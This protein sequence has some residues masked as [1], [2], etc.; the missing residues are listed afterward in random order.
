M[1]IRMKNR[2]I[3]SVLAIIIFSSCGDGLGNSYKDLFN[4]IEH[5]YVSGITLDSGVFESVYFGKSVNLHATL[6]PPDATDQKVTWSIVSGSSLASVNSEKGILRA[7]NTAGDIRVRAV[8]RDGGFSAE[9]VITI[10]GVILPG[11]STIAV[12]HGKMQ[13]SFSKSIYNYLDAPIPWSVSSVSIIP[14]AVQGGS[15]IM[16]NGVPAESGMPYNL[17]VNTGSNPVSVV[18]TAADGLSYLTYDVDIYRAVPVYKTGAGSINGYILDPREDGSIRRG[19]AWPNPR[20]S[21]NGNGTITDKM[22]GLVWIKNLVPHGA[23]NDWNNSLSSSEN[24]I[25][26]GKTDWRLPNVR[27]LLSMH[28]WGEPAQNWLLKSGFTG[29]PSELKCW[30]SSIDPATSS[31]VWGVY[32]NYAISIIEKNSNQYT[33]D[34]YWWAVRSGS[35]LQSTGQTN[36]TTSGEDGFYQKGV[37][38]PIKHFCI[39]SNGTI[40]DNMTGLV[41]LKDANPGTS[42]LTW[43]DCLKY[44]D[45]LNAGIKSG[46]CGFTNWRIPTVNEILSIIDFSSSLNFSAWLSSQGFLNAQSGTAYFYV[47]S[48]TDESYPLNVW[49]ISRND[50][51]LISESKLSGFQMLLVRSTE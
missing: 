33:A 10:S 6:S 36:N 28:N 34:S 19:E 9:C 14:S 15:E 40:T 51:S 46:N 48:T 7:G 35:K 27:E 30:S 42:P 31:K 32:F 41:W 24:L 25:Y 47:T 2:I 21:D 29:V 16:I 49:S 43:K 13:P 39:N 20:F 17:A 3:F 11:L 8:T 4:D 44:A 1:V 23:A 18:V 38:I 5:I 12:S 37:S 22:S 26:A 45:E 50:R